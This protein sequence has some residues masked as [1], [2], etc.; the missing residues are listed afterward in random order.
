MNWT[1][2]WAIWLVVVAGSFAVLE[3]LALRDSRTG[4]TLS[5]NTR[6]WLGIEPA[7]RIRRVA[8]PA[9]VA[10]LVGFVVWFI[11]HIVVRWGW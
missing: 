1:V 5:E 10:V 8:V 7:H 11:P 6:R 9:F 4:D 3:G 2:T